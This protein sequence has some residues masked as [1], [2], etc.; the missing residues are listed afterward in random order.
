MKSLDISSVN[1]ALLKPFLDP[2]PVITECPNFVVSDFFEA[3]FLL[4]DND[5]DHYKKYRTTQKIGHSGVTA[6]RSVLTGKGSKNGVSNA[7]L[8]ILPLDDC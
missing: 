4:A 5:N 7:L 8:T 3:E 6:K 2:F 1:R